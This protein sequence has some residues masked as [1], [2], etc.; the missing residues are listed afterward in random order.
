MSLINQMLK[1][2]EERGVNNADTEVEVAS[3]LTAANPE[4][5]NQFLLDNAPLSLI[6]M[7]SLM[8]LLAGAAYLWTQNTQAQSSLAQP[9]L[10]P[11]QKITQLPTKPMA[12]APAHEI[13]PVN[14][15]LQIAAID[16][17]NLA[18]QHE[19]PPLFE[20]ELKFNLASLEAPHVQ[21]KSAQKKQA[22]AHLNTAPEPKIQAVTE[23]ITAPVNQQSTK[24]LALI[25]KPS[26]KPNIDTGF[27]DKQ[28][29]PEQKSTNLY[30]QALTYLQQGRVAEAQAFLSSALEASPINH[31]ARQ[32]LAGL[33]LDNKRHDEAK[34][35]LAAGV[36]IAPEHIDFRM[37]LARLQVESGD[38]NAA[39]NTLEQGLA[40]AKNN[41]NYQIF[42]ATLLQRTNRHIDAIAHY[43][44]ALS[45]HSASNDAT[46]SALVG[47]AISLQAMDKLT[48]SQEAFTRAQ[49]SATLS[50]ELLS[51]VEQRIKQIN[52][53][54]QN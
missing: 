51:F 38:I 46:A 45:L 31:E 9:S 20:T 54:L 16:P 7:G 3:N 5:S 2:L 36:A 25:E 4:N 28:I 29:R 42:L 44:T 21:E 50:P 8:V 1:D 48:E 34:A 41:G 49:S 23:A 17:T 32:T 47:L 27:I 6:K 12:S 39:L 53:R 22:L 10:A 40:Y 52:Q 14:S 35:T 11:Q 19:A 37:T 33:L 30:K 26:N 13:T 18:P 15:T 24:K 43:N